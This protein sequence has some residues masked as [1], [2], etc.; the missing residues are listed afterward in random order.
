[1]I[2]TGAAVLTPFGDLAA[3][4]RG[5][6]GATAIGLGPH[7]G[8]SS[9]VVSDA[10]ARGRAA[11][12]LQ[13]AAAAALAQA[14]VDRCP[15]YVGTCSGAMDDFE[16]WRG[17]PALPWYGAP[18]ASLGLSP[19]YTFSSACTSSLAALYAAVR[20]GGGGPILVAGADGLCSFTTSGFAALRATS[21]EPC[22]P[23]SQTRRGLSFG[24]GAA[25]L[26]IESE[27]SAHA[28]GAT[29]LG[30]VRGV[31]LSSDASHRTAPRA[32][33]AGLAR[34]VRLACPEPAGVDVYVSHGTGT[35]ASDAAELAF[36]ARAGLIGKPWLAHKAIL[37]HAMGASGLISLVLALS[38]M[39]E[40]A[41][42]SVPYDDV[43]PGVRL[44]GSLAGAR[45][46]LIVAAAFGGSNAAAW[47]SV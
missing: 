1:M 11:F 24:E 9:A 14:Q 20:A 15:A 7:A 23:F 42:F 40:G 27:A 13:R 12:F 22:R 25:A 21:P 16:T 32:D 19:A 6:T 33:A 39:R 17:G 43:A 36:G 38:Q 35:V 37:G 5:L 18:A 29:A 4:L 41:D 47:V 3:S 10:P 31:G 2:I 46:A 34:A 45:S 30:V 44:H 26:V 8:T 28:R